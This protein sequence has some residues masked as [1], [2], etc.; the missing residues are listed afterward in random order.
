FR[1][2]GNPASPI[3]VVVELVVALG[4]FWGTAEDA[5]FDDDDRGSA[6]DILPLRLCSP[7]PSA[8]PSGGSP[9]AVV[10]SPGFRRFELQPALKEG[11]HGAFF[12][13]EG[14]ALVFDFVLRQ[15]SKRLHHAA[16]Q[17][18]FQDGRV[19]VALPADGGGVPQALGDS[20][21]GL[22]DV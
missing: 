21:D 22:D 3:V 11:Q 12:A 6:E 10:R 9:S 13:G 15:L 5:E 2:Q 4:F 19:D 8:L 17:V 16:L 7:L 1:G 18:G 14:A 20:I